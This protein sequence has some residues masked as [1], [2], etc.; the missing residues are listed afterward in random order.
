MR[1]LFD[2]IE[3][4]DQFFVETNSVHRIYVE[5]CGNPDGVPILFLHGGPCSGCKPDH[6]RFFDPHV[7]RIIL[8]D[9][10]GCGRSLPFGELTAN[11]LQTIIDDME[12]IRHVL[13]LTS[14]ILYGGSWGA[15]LALAYAQKHTQAVQGMILRGT[16][17]ARQQDL[18][19]FLGENGAR[20]IYPEMSDLLVDSIPPAL[21]TQNLL[22]DIIT[23]LNSNDEQAVRSVTQAWQLWGGQVA[24][25]S[26][27]QPPEMMITEQDV[28]QAKMELHYAQHHYFLADN[29][30]LANCAILKHIPAIIIHGRN[31]LVCPLESGWQ[32]HKHLPHAQFILLP[33][34]GHIAQG[35]EM[36]DALLSATEAMKNVG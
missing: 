9:Q 20:L 36:I 5:Q 12:Q 35:E 24:L 14:W 31:D 29:E 10:R 33:N 26:L 25:G 7:Y 16:F 22:A 15:T 30:L 19:W 3:P 21:R 17:L 34:S 8:F 28:T 32:L 4:F 1:T 27:F 23:T 11:S 18:E 13:G 6:R 2:P